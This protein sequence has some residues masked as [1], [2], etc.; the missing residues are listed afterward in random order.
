MGSEG[1]VLMIFVFWKVRDTKKCSEQTLHS[2]FYAA[3]PDF[4]KIYS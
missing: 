2:E 1:F 3:N 4:A